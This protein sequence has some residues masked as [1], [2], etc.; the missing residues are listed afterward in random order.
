LKAFDFTPS[1]RLA[2]ITAKAWISAYRAHPRVTGVVTLVGTLSGAMGLVLGFVQDRRD[3]EERA[4]L[5]AQ[6]LTYPY[7]LES[8]TQLERNTRNVLTFVET[9]RRDLLEMQKSLE[10]LRREREQIRPLVEADRRAVDAVFAE[11]TKR[12]GADLMRERWIG[13]AVGVISSIVAS[14]VI[15]AVVRIWRMRVRWRVRAPQAPDSA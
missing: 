7:Q 6:Q 9:Q 12:A 10:Q 15:G 14:I 2:E 8:L 3:A 13:F 1:Q 4:R 11:Q 5:R